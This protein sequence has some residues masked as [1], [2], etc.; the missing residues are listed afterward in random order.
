M[1]GRHQDDAWQNA[2]DLSKVRAG[3]AGVIDRDTPVMSKSGLNDLDLGL[4]TPSVLNDEV[5]LGGTANPYGQGGF[6]MPAQ[7]QGSAHPHP[8]D[9]NS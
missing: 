5:G 8:H 6:G 1:G 9:S 2:Q 4:G 3:I 7:G